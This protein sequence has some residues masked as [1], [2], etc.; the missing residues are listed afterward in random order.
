M[1]GSQKMGVKYM[2]DKLT[3]EDIKNI[4]NTPRNSQE[5]NNIAAVAIQLADV[6]HENKEIFSILLEC[7]DNMIKWGKGECS[8]F[9]SINKV[10]SNKDT[11]HF[12]DPTK[13]VENSTRNTE[14]K[15]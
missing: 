7:R 12:R 13:M 5:D 11:D 1:D 15:L 14:D 6:M 9:Y 8:F 4:I 10:L 2:I 3:K